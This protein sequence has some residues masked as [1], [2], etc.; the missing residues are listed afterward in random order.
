[1]RERR[2]VWRKGESE[3]EKEGERGL[4]ERGRERRRGERGREREERGRDCEREKRLERKR[5]DR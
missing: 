5:G 1:M 4:K 3:E 2:R